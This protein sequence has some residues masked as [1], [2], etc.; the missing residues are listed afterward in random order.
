MSEV[1]ISHITEESAEASAISFY[2]RDRLKVEAFQSSRIGQMKGGK[3]WLEQL[4][5]AL[6]GCR[7][8]LSLLSEQ[9]IKEPWI[10]F[11]AGAAWIS[12]KPVIPCCYGGLKKGALPQPFASLHGYDMPNDLFE[13]VLCV[14]DHLSLPIILPPPSLHDN[15]RKA[16]E[17]AFHGKGWH[18]PLQLPT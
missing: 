1:F 3:E 11:E 10:N 8:M 2:L 7:V 16:V 9:S 13:L 4:R 12:R 6:Q 5:S 14:K 17:D 18:P 15:L